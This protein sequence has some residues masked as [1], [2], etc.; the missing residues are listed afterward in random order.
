MVS[1]HELLA[2]LHHL[3]QPKLYVET[4]VHTGASLNLAS[5]QA[6]GIDPNPLVYNQRMNQ[7]VVK[8]TSDEYFASGVELPGFIDLGFIDGLHHY[9]AAWRDFI[10]MERWATSHSVIVFDDVLP[11]T[12]EMASREMTLGDWTGDVW[13]VYYILKETREDLSFELVDTFPTGTL[14][15]WDVDPRYSKQSDALLHP[16]WAGGD[17]V[18]EE[19]LFRSTAISAEDVVNK[20]K[21]WRG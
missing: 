1:R 9:D 17:T 14:V 3:L 20:L 15:V 6:I 10:N 18:P 16:E 21:E 19:I 4:G 5:C 8:M 11:Y 12:N 7:T 13:K 2:R